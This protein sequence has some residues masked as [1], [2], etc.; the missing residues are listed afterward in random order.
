[1]KFTHMYFPLFISVKVNI[2]ANNSPWC[3][4]DMCGK[5]H[6]EA[7]AF[8]AGSRLVHTFLTGDITGIWCNAMPNKKQNNPSY[9]YNTV[10]GTISPHALHNITHLLHSSLYPYYLFP[11]WFMLVAWKQKNQVSPDRSYAST[12]VHGVTSKNNVIWTNVHNM[13]MAYLLKSYLYHKIQTIF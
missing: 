3:A 10:N 4:C 6:N 2:M 5:T 13:V 11:I 1:M 9:W 7:Y 12:K 8:N